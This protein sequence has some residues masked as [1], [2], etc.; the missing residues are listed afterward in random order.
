MDFCLK[1]ESTT[2]KGLNMG[3]IAQF[4]LLNPHQRPLIHRRRLPDS[5]TAI[6]KHLHMGSLNQKHMPKRAQI[7]KTLSR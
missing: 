7:I 6:S 4:R 3:H 2:S 1:R 5:H